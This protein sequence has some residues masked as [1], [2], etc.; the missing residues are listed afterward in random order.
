MKTAIF[1]F[2]VLQLVVWAFVFSDNENTDTQ[3][4]QY[5]SLSDTWIVAQVGDNNANE[6]LAHYPT[7]NKLTLNLNGTYVRLRDDETLEE[8]SWKIN[9]EKN[10]LTLFA[11]SGAQN[12][13]IVELPSTNSGSFIIIE[14]LVQSNIKGDIKYELTRL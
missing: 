10:T 12:F 4:V 3:Q 6:V 9:E 2:L 7:F 13:E 14:S 5:A 8:G 11:T 1:N